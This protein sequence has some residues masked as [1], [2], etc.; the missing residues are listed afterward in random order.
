MT[1][2]NFDE[3]EMLCNLIGLRMAVMQLLI[4]MESLP[5]ISK[6]FDSLLSVGRLY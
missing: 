3:V 4:C 1:P 6:Q 5:H 2:A